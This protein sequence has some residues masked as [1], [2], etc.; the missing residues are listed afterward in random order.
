MEFID[1]LKVA[2]CLDDLK[3]SERKHVCT[4]IGK[5]LALLLTILILF[6]VT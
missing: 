6:M 1:G 2:D 3:D 5:N 4:E